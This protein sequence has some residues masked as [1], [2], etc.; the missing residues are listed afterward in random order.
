MN[1]IHTVELTQGAHI[2]V[3]K[4][5]STGDL[6][7]PLMLYEASNIVPKWLAR[8]PTTIDMRPHTNAGK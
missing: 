6:M 7:A 8:N 5:P 2:P 4:I 1:D 3:K